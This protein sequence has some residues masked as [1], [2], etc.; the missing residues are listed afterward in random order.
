M[1]LFGDN[2]DEIFDS[3][4]ES[5]SDE[6]F[7]GSGSSTNENNDTSECSNNSVGFG[8]FDGGFD[9]EKT[10]DCSAQNTCTDDSS[11]K[12]AA[13]ACII[14]GA[15]L[16][17]VVTIIYGRTSNKG[18]S[19][20]NNT[21]SSSKNVSSTNNSNTSGYA[22]FTN[23]GW[24]KIS[25]PYAELSKQLEGVMTIT[26]LNYFA[27]TIDGNSAKLEIRMVATGAIDGMEGA[28]EIELPYRIKDVLEIG[29]RISIYYSIAEVSNER[30]V[31]DLTYR[32][33][34]N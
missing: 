26:D 17:T 13:I 14:I 4:S 33:V 5:S 25:D 21:E 1:G 31:I 10:M 23:N 3:F 18:K 16:I 24:I 32:S 20:T 30:S 12:K 7:F 15:L 2:D 19:N 9:S 27:R 22:Q 28:Y 29:S 8:S 34:D 6:S 11:K